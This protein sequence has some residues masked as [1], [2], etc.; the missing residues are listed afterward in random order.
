MTI[1]EKCGKNEALAHFSRANSEEEASV[2][3]TAENFCEPCAKDFMRATPAR[4]RLTFSAEFRTGEPRKQVTRSYRVLRL[5]PY[6]NQVEIEVLPEFSIS[7][8]GNPLRIRSDLIPNTASRA[9]E[10]FKV[11]GTP[12]EID[13]IET[14]C[15]SA[16]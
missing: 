9:G 11:T 6:P 8:H 2:P 4:K 3:T 12:L 14:S 1:C 15:K 5:L 10:T 7:L 16:Y 13:L